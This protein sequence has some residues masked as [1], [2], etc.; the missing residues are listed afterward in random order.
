MW[1]IKRLG[2]YYRYKV[3]NRDKKM[4]HKS[5]S[6]AIYEIGLIGAAVYFIQQAHGFTEGVIAI[7]KAIFWPAVVLYRVL[8]LLKL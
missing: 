1:L 7:G 6:D 5:S 8:E 4:K 3:I 2:V